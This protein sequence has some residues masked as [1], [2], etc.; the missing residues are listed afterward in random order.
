MDYIQKQV[1]PLTKFYRPARSDVLVGLVSRAIKKD[2]GR[3]V[4][5]QGVGP[6]VGA[7][8]QTVPAFVHTL[9]WGAKHSQVGAL[10]IDKGVAEP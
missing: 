4:D 3:A 8:A 10:R 2:F 1:G 6:T 5:F 7:Q 9:F